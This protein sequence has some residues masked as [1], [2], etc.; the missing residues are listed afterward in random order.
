MKTMMNM[1]TIL[2]LFFFNTLDIVSG[3]IYHNHMVLRQPYSIRFNLHSSKEIKKINEHDALQLT[4]F[5][6]DELKEQ[7]RD[8]ISEKKNLQNINI[9]YSQ[10]NDEYLKMS[11]L[12][13]FNYNLQSKQRCDTEYLIWKP[14]ISPVFITDTRSNSILYP[15]FRQTLCLVSFKRI[16]NDIDVENMIFSPFW[17]GDSNIIQKNVK[18]V[19]IDYFLTYMK[20]NTINY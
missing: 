3:Y 20:H 17:N 4:R 7:Q 15:C 8:M 16:Y 11:N 5:W 9:L 14:K 2:L 19:L 6:Y 10:S 18:S 12:M 13:N 1:N